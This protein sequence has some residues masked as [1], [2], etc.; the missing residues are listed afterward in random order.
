VTCS[1][2]LLY[3]QS[4]AVVNLLANHDEE[5]SKKTGLEIHLHN[6]QLL[7]TQTARG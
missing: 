7:K 4:Q 1:Y 5:N 6:L 3:E 2:T